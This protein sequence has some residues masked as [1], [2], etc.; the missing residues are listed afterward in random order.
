MAH[1]MRLNKHLGAGGA[2]STRHI[3]NPK[4][5]K[6]FILSFK[7]AAGVA[8]VISRQNL[9]LICFADVTIGRLRVDTDATAVGKQDNNAHGRRMVLIYKTKMHPGSILNPEQCTT[10][11]DRSNRKRWLTATL[12]QMDQHQATTG[13]PHEHAHDEEIQEQQQPPPQQQGDLPP[14]GSGTATPAQTPS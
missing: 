7:T 14:G 12:Q 8:L 4:G 3:Q 13:Q 6:T 10:K 2:M 9:K 1:G 11:M 5:A